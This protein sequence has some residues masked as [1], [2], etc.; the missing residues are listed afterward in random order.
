MI[1]ILFA[2][3][4][5]VS[6]LIKITSSG[7]AF[8]LQERIGQYGR[9][10]TIYKFRTMKVNT[11]VVESNGRIDFEYRTV[12]GKIVRRFSIDEW[13]QFY[14]ILQGT[15][16]FIGPRPLILDSQVNVLRQQYP[17]VTAL[18]PG[19]SGLAQVN[20]RNNLNNREKVKFDLQ[21]AD[22]ISLLVDLKI[23]LKSF[24]VVFYGRGIFGVKK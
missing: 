13:P 4:T 18:K 12:I 21:Y 15:M 3:G 2:P 16:S 22:T 7:P 20:G 24:A 9:P 23:A 19:L 10:F 6:I 11:P 8:Y 1:I 5:L 14:N 17:K